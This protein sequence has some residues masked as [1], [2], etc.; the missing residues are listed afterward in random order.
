MKMS[1]ILN[2][3]YNR[4]FTY[5]QYTKE[6]KKLGLTYDEYCTFV[7]QK[8]SADNSIAKSKLF[9]KEILRTNKY[10]YVHSVLELFNDEVYRFDTPNQHPVIIDC[11]TNIG[12]S[13]IYFKKLFP[14]SK[15][16]GFEAD[17]NLFNVCQKNLASFKLSDIQLI[18]AAVWN[19]EGVVKF[20]SDNSLGGKISDNTNG[21]NLIEIK[22]VKLSDYLDKKID[23]LKIDIEGAEY[24]VLKECQDHLKNVERLFVEYHS[25]LHS[26]Q[27]LDELLEIFKGAGFR[28][29][30]EVAGKVMQH[31]FTEHT[32]LKNGFD[33]QL[34]ISCYRP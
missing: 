25:D 26:D 11:G 15:V 34:N 27:R 2:K 9:G 33:L 3:I 20:K 4:T 7:W 12:L 18:N 10:W 19:K 28:Y 17:P 16:L 32:S 23:F 22:T 5:W 14:L 8:Y 30:I 6:V 24:E 13:L 29:Y 31:P 1:K 21:Q